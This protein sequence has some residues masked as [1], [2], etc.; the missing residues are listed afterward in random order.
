MIAKT[1]TVSA[2]HPS[3]QV[4]AAVRAA[5]PAMAIGVALLLSA[6]ATT[7][8]TDPALEQA[9]AAVHMLETDP[10]AMQSA[11]KPLQ[12]AREALAAAE[13]AAKA[14]RPP[15]EIDHLAYLASRRADIG[16]A[17]VAETRARND[18]A[19]AQARRDRVLIESREHETEVAREQTRD[20]QV[21]AG[22][23]QAQAQAQVDASKAQALASQADAEAT[24]EQLEEL[25]AKQ[26]ERGMVVTLGSNVLFDTN[27]AELKPGASDAIDR[28]GQFLQKHT[29]L[30]VRIE[31]HTD[32]TGSDSYNQELSQRRADAVAHALESRGADPSNI[33]TV[34]RGSELPV[35]TNDSAAGRQQNRRVELVFSDGEGQFA[36]TGG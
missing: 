35:A 10:L 24:R 25:Q 7:P 16:E 22:E 36:R 33:Q 1:S 17:V 4:A 21:Q 29:N 20:A 11:G 2:P 31:G 18:I 13:A 3:N 15:E 27:R 9:R 5:L 34:G 6:C 23:V 30:K 12:D 14:K 19:Q 26:T 8:F 28:V 32:S